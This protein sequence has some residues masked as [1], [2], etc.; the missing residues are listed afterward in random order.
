MAY[1]EVTMLEVK[2]VLRLWRGGTARKRI[3]AQLGLASRPSGR[4]I[5]AAEA[6]GIAR[7]AGPEALP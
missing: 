3:A 7:E 6:S 5:A 1:R 4:Y 2:E